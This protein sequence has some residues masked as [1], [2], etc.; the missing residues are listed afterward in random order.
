MNALQT[1]AVADGMCDRLSGN[2]TDYRAMAASE[3]HQAEAQAR[4]EHIVDDVVI[5]WLA[6]R[7]DA[8]IRSHGGGTLLSLI[9]ESLC[10][11]PGNP[12]RELM[13]IVRLVARRP[14]DELCRRAS[15][16]MEQLAREHAEAS[17]DREGV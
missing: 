7:L 14:D 11:V 1:L 15:A 9:S 16:A 17:V 12:L 3:Q 13:E 10:D 2:G 8:P 5:A 6:G 4:V